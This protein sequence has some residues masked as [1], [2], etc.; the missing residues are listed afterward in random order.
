M[1]VVV[2][3][4][5][6]LPKS[7]IYQEL[8]ALCDRFDS[9]DRSRGLSG[10]AIEIASLASEVKFLCWRA[11]AADDPMTSTSLRYEIIHKIDSLQI[12]LGT[13]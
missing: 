13:H 10:S 4:T 3:N 9:L 8:W 11:Y 7:V 6:N 2:A 12:L 1:K 5:K